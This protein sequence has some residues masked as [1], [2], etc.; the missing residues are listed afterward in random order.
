[1]RVLRAAAMRLATRDGISASSEVN[2]LRRATAVRADRGLKTRTS[3]IEHRQ[4]ELGRS[5][6]PAAQQRD[7]CC[8]DTSSCCNSRLLGPCRKPRRKSPSCPQAPFLGAGTTAMSLVSHLWGTKT[9]VHAR[10]YSQGQPGTQ[11]T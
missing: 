8:P 1:M 2:C 9:D 4:G 10:S 5:P 3:S 6:H 7:S 11:M